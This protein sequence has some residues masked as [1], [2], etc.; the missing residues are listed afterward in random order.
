[1]RWQSQFC[2]TGN[3]TSLCLSM[4]LFD[5]EF[6]LRLSFQQDM[7]LLAPTSI[8][9]LLFVVYWLIRCFQWQEGRGDWHASLSPSTHGGRC[10][11][12]C[13]MLWLFCPLHLLK[14]CFCQATLFLS[15]Y[16]PSR[17][18]LK[19][20]TQNAN[21]STLTPR[22]LSFLVVPLFY[23]SSSHT[24]FLITASRGWLQL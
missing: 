19:T 8:C 24:S 2:V 17:F 20:H 23:F 11:V 12:V 3:R 5:S 9:S 4:V 21:Y 13:I 16:I 7:S 14:S 22:C 10:D 1:M 18:S 6:Q 15:F